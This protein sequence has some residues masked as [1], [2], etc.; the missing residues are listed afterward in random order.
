MPHSALV[1]QSNESKLKSKVPWI[2]KDIISKVTTRAP[3][4]GTGATQDF[5]DVFLFHS[6]NSLLVINKKYEIGK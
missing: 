4:P 3:F 1:L 5:F 2:G 6:S